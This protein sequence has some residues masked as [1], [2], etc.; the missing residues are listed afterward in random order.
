MKIK[1]L[2]VANSKRFVLTGIKEITYTPKATYQMIVGPNGVGKSSLIQLLSPY[3]TTVGKRFNK[4]GG[5]EITISH[6]NNEYILKSGL[7][8]NNRHSFIVNN[9]ELNEGGTLRIQTE[10]VFEHFGIDL[11]IHELIVGEKL[12]TDLKPQERK[13]LMQRL[14]RNDYEYVTKLYNTHKT[15]LRDIKGALKIAL[16]SRSQELNI[17]DDVKYKDL[18]SRIDKLKEKEEKIIKK[19]QGYNDSDAELTYEELRTKLS[20]SNT[21]LQAFLENNDSSKESLEEILFFIK[22]KEQFIEGLSFDLEK[23]EEKIGLLEQMKEYNDGAYEECLRDINI[24]QDKIRKITSSIP[25]NLD[26]L[27]LVKKAQYLKDIYLSLDIEKLEQLKVDIA[28]LSGNAKPEELNKQVTINN[29]IIRNLKAKEIS[30]ESLIAHSEEHDGD[31]TCPKCSTSFNPNLK[32]KT[33]DE[34][35]EELSEIRNELQMYENRNNLLHR[36]IALHEKRFDIINKT[37]R[38]LENPYVTKLIYKIYEELECDLSDDFKT[39]KEALRKVINFIPNLTKY[40]KYTINLR[41]L[42]ERLEDMKVQKELSMSSLNGLDLDSQLEIRAKLKKRI[43]HHTVELKRLNMVKERLVK[44]KEE[45]EYNRNVREQM[46]QT[47]LSE[48]KGVELRMLEDVLTTVKEERQNLEMII[49]EDMKN[50][51]ILKIEQENIERLKREYEVT[52]ELVDQLSPNKGIIGKA[53]ETFMM[54][55]LNRVNAIIKEFW[56]FDVEVMPCVFNEN[57][58]IDYNFPVVINKD[59]Y[60]KDISEGS[61]GM[62]EIFN[63]AFKLVAMD[64]L[65]MGEYP[66]FLDEFASN[67]DGGHRS[68]AYTLLDK[69]KKRHSNVFMISHF[70]EFYGSLKNMDINVLSTKNILLDNVETYNQRIKIVRS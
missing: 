40:E 29:N 15:A 24:Y 20:E 13:V 14:D 11:L 32:G 8:L 19:M 63:L 54:K 4:G 41:T 60:L 68:R 44:L 23:T 62:Q 55:F 57:G 61:K 56:V 6:N 46:F 36:A 64:L 16:N 18:N 69:I 10:L 3:P 35:K 48:V 59:T 28:E 37:K 65:G 2:Y 26:A 47:S 34:L 9:E 22:K 33:V 1:N 51:H 21:R 70:V 5:S 49:N 27:E 38:M 66:I 39:I 42:Q 52:Q 7:D 30:L 45:L 58:K 31:V 53:L 12:F 50:R 67:M 43:F 17:M 25:F